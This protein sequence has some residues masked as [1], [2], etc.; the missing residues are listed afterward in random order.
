VG[1]DQTLG[2]IGQVP[3]ESL[4]AGDTVRIHWRAEPYREKWL[5]CAVGSAEA[6]VTV[7]GVLGPDGQMPVVDGGQATCR[8]TPSFHGEDRAVIK[9]GSTRT[10]PTVQPRHIVIENLEVRSARP[11][12]TFQGREGSASYRANAAAIW[13][14]SG[15]G[16][17]VRNCRLHDC[18][19]GLVSS[20]QTRDV[21][22]EGCSIY[23]NGTE[24]GIYQHNVYTES[25]GITFQYN[26]LGP[27]RADAF[28]INLKD[29]SAGT[30]IRYNWIEGG[31]RLIDLV[32]S[33]YPQLYQR[34]DY[35]ESFVN[36]NVLIKLADTTNPQGCHY[37]G[38][39]SDP[40]KFR[41]GTLYFTHNTVVSR[42]LGPVTLFRLSSASD[43]AIIRNNIFWSRSPLGH[44]QLMSSLGTAYLGTNWFPRE[45]ASMLR[46]VGGEEGV[47][48]EK[49]QILGVDPGFR[50]PD[51]GD[52]TLAPG[53]ACV[54]RADPLPAAM[55][56]QHAC[57]AEYVQHGGHRPR[58]AGAVGDLGAFGPVQ[59]KTP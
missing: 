17:T 18:G 52:F 46:F 16:L 59:E 20:H 54:G 50:D 32:E 41:N 58:A 57:T 24:L 38:D 14:E 53:S 44:I 48:V 31:N 27:L 6:P 3:W 15:E 39:Q 51:K 47:Y 45:F 36:G 56:P 25:E 33:D 11:I 19:N 28:G 13:L 49:E 23:G 35:R 40:A 12:N 4:A 1:P 34:P 55:L 9:V 22:V 29:R 21:L 2:A 10:E 43:K 42:L 30:I 8:A 26:H 37:G 7:T 5:I